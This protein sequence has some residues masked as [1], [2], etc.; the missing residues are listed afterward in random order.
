MEFWM[1]LWK[2]VFIVSVGAFSVMSIWVTV[3]GAFDIR[4]LLR[5]LRDEHQKN[6]A[7]ER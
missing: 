5:T 4:S 6:R 2:F 3:Q 1:V 7:A